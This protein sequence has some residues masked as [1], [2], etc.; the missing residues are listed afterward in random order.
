MNLEIK[1]E[2]DFEYVD[3][4]SGPVLI[5]LHGLFGA[6][7]NFKDVVDNFKQKYRVIVPLMP[8]FKLPIA[9]TN[10]SSL[11]K[12]VYDFIEYKGL[13]E[14]IMLGNSLGGHV[15]LVYASK[16]AEK[17][18]AMVLTGS[19]GLYEN[20]LGGSY[21]R[22]DDYEFIKGRVAYTFY[23]PKHAD[24]ELVGEVFRTLNDREKAIRIIAL[25]KS[26]MRHNM[27]DELPGIQTPTLLIWGKNDNITPP[28]VGEEFKELIPNSD[29]FWIDQC[30]HA[31]MMEQAEEFNHILEKWLNDKGLN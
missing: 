10:V 16:H 30:G 26:A 6:L 4:G 24:D 3:E 7:S 2:N 17:L 15:A 5:L 1:H 14:I 31:P 27:K 28:E 25:A 18:R 9:S 21:P 12:Y 22:K 8:L 19:S 11:Y 13:S 20:S 29:L 23:D